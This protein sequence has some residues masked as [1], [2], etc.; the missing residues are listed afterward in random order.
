MAVH[1]TALGGASRPS[2][3]QPASVPSN[4]VVQP[5]ASS[6][7]AFARVDGLALDPAPRL[8]L[9]VTPAP[10]ASPVCLFHQ[11]PAG[12]GAGGKKEHLG[13]G[14]SAGGLLFPYYVGCYEALKENGLMT[15]ALRRALLG[16]ATFQ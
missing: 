11:A 4:S 12:K 1:P 14:F 5:S 8:A 9:R 16:R 13:F 2:S 3:V 15:G 6:P 10:A 7:A